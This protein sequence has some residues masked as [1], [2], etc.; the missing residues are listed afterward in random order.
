M[1]RFHHFM[2]RGFGFKGAMTLKNVGAMADA[3]A[4]Q[5]ISNKPSQPSAYE[6][7]VAERINLLKFRAGIS[8]RKNVQEYL[9][10]K[11]EMQHK[12]SELN[13]EEAYSLYQQQHAS[14]T[15]T[16]GAAA[17]EEEG[18]NVVGADTA[19]SLNAPA[20]SNAAGADPATD[21]EV[22]TVVPP[23]VRVTK[24]PSVDGPVSVGGLEFDAASSVGDASSFSPPL[25]SADGQFGPNIGENAL[26]T[27]GERASISI[28]PT[29]QAEKSAGPTQGE[30]DVADGSGGAYR[31][32][33]KS[34]INSNKV[35][36]CEHEMCRAKFGR[37]VE[38][39][40]WSQVSN[41]TYCTFCW[42]T[43]SSHQPH[44]V[45]VSY[46][47][48][49]EA[50]QGRKETDAAAQSSGD[51]ES[52]SPENNDIWHEEGQSGGGML[53]SDAPQFHNAAILSTLCEMHNPVTS[54]NI[55]PKDTYG[56]IEGVPKGAS[57]L[58]LETKDRDYLAS[59]VPNMTHTSVKV[60]R[61]YVSDGA[62]KPPTLHYNATVQ[63]SYMND[64]TR[65]GLEGVKTSIRE[66]EFLG[67]EAKRR[68]DILMKREAKVSEQIAALAIVLWKCD[69]NLLCAK[70]AACFP[71]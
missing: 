18:E 17:E 40:F 30:V 70:P 23:D 59:L 58:V 28:S 9:R 67:Q 61:S 66:K 68:R 26:Q 31:R 55:K 25:F 64:E 12:L 51:A 10:E 7:K 42:D 49:S 48:S 8:G 44:G 62:L 22:A 2:C 29:R 4:E 35:V 39:A 45:V 56:H 37:I 34:E 24:T 16:D 11:Q 47:E 63:I 14:Y 46:G 60:G 57:E 5:K 38:A 13:R 33:K 20:T 1:R 27:S 15:L 53:R 54:S 50:E 3:V 52:S 43:I 69:L 36:W 71:S 6:K 21:V 32:R 65:R 41:K 19:A